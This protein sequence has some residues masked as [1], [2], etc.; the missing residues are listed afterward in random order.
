MLRSVNLRQLLK[1]LL[2]KKPLQLT[3]VKMER[4]KQKLTKRQPMKYRQRPWNV[5][6]SQAREMVMKG[7]EPKKKKKRK[8]GSDVVEFLREKAKLDHALKEE[9]LQ[10]RKDQQSQTML[11]S[12]TTAAATNESSISVLCQQMLSKEK[13]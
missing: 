8:S 13:H 5:L 7:R 10:L 6:D 3:V 4:R 9:E 2:A 12:S 11:F 1:I